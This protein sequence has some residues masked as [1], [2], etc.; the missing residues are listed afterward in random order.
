M[1]EQ[2]NENYFVSFQY[3]KDYFLYGNST[4]LFHEEQLRNIKH[5][6]NTNSF[7]VTIHLNYDSFTVK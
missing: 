4:L 5:Y 7:V 3:I 1:V 2:F 6:I